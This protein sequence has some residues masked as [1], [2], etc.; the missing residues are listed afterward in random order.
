MPKREKCKMIRSPIKV[1]ERPAF[2]LHDWPLFSDG[3]PDELVLKKDLVAL[4]N[5][6]DKRGDYPSDE[7]LADAM[8]K[9]LEDDCVCRLHRIEELIADKYL[10]DIF[11]KVANAYTEALQWKKMKRS[12]KRAW[13]L[14]CQVF[15]RTK[16]PQFCEDTKLPG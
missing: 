7:E 2:D 3:T 8:M 9:A 11:L 15:F 12:R 13:K 5:F 16:N 1:E 4:A 14:L 10:W 6:V